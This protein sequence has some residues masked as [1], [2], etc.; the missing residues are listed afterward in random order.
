MSRAK[1]RCNSDRH[2]RRKD[3]KILLAIPSAR[4]IETECV[5]SLF[6]MEKTGD[7]EL[8]IPKSYSVDVGRNIIAKYAQENGFDYI[9]WVDS[10]MIL[11]KNTLV[12]LL[13]HDKDI[14][15]GV[16]SYKVLGNKEVVAKRFQDETREEYDN[17]T[18]KEI[19]ESSG[20]I[21]VDGFGFGCVL[22]K[23]SMFD[24]IPYPW[25][26]YTQE[27]GEDI[28]FCRKA[29]NEGYKLWL[30]TDVICGHIGQINYDI[31]KG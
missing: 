3:M 9:M 25:F 8:F 20:L 14:V 4:Y 12:R 16:Y 15:S 2:E 31:K 27:M 22:T 1:S 17:L 23:T 24:K 29:Q 11:P 26:I 21:E 19:K 6:E 13:S 30:D 7:I 5:T 28:F 18:I 10:D